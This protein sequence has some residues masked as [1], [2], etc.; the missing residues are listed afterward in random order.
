M[1]KCDLKATSQLTFTCPK[2]MIETVE[3]GVNYVQTSEVDLVFLLLTL[4]I[5]HTFFYCFYCYFE[6]GNVN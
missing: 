4:N 5:L 6:Q 3:K 1:P 2:S